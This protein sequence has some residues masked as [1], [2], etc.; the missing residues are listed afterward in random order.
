MITTDMRCAHRELEGR[1][2]PFVARRVSSSA[3][4]DDVIQDVFLRMLR[5]VA[6]LREEDRF[7]P[8]V[9]QIARSAIAS[10]R[11]TRS[12]HPLATNPPPEAAEDPF[13]IAGDCAAEQEVAAY[14]AQLI[15]TLPTPY[16][17]A[18]TLTE[19]EGLTQAEAAEMMG[20]T[21]SGMKS[22]VQR[23]REQLRKLV[24][25]CCEIALD[26]RGRVIGCA[27]RTGGRYRANCDCESE[28]RQNR[29]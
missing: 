25:Q 19:L 1:L 10:Y 18:L 12:R 7:G 15:A 20:L 3:D 26:A 24:N 5:S 13:E 11:R 28:D 16:R 6:H 27:P 14:T 2:R 4:V 21:V 17:E 22:R 23:G 29:V 9:Y 8:W